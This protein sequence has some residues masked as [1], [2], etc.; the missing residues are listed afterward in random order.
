M[1]EQDLKKLSRADLLE[2]LV[3][4][5]QKIERLQRQLDVANRKLADRTIAIEQSGSLAEASLAVNGVFR[6][7]EAACAQYTENI[8]ARSEAQE[9]ICARMEQETQAKCEAMLA[10]AERQ[11]QAY[12][13]QV[14]DRVRQ[15][16]TQSKALR[17]LL[18]AIKEERVH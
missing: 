11:S 5:N 18:S 12:W 3:Q 15:L 10:D 4:Q 1:N 14:E 13:N 9:S 6:A 7:A 8:R 2:V 17:E 16:V